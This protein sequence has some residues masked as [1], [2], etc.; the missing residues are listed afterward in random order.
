MKLRVSSLASVEWCETKALYLMQGREVPETE[1]M[2]RGRMW[3][4]LFGFDHDLLVNTVYRGYEIEGHIDKLIELPDGKK[5][6]VEF[7]T[8]GEGYPS[9][10][11]LRYA[12]TQANL[13]AYM[14][15]AERYMVILFA[16]G[17]EEG[18]G[19]LW[20]VERMR[21]DFKAQAVLGRAIDLLERKVKP[22]PVQAKWKCL[23]CYFFPECKEKGVI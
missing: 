9:Y 18:M 23:K 8:T 16:P 14:I 7:K 10:E 22:E 19:T 12:Y 6:V 20:G 15:K 4:K 21:D 5:I 1:E 17:D 13:Y 11:L 2:R 3:H